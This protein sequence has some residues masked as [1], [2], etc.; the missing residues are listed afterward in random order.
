MN[1]LED[2]NGADTNGKTET[3]DLRNTDEIDFIDRYFSGGLKAGEM[4]I[5]IVGGHLM[6]YPPRTNILLHTLAKRLRDSG[7]DVKLI[8]PF[9]FDVVPEDFYKE[10]NFEPMT[11]ESADAF[12]ESL[13]EKLSKVD[14]DKTKY[15]TIDSMPSTIIDDPIAEEIPFRSRGLH[16]G[17]PAV[18]AVAFVEPKVELLHQSLR[19]DILKHRDDIPVVDGREVIPNDMRF[20]P[21]KFP[22]HRQEN[23]WEIKDRCAMRHEDNYQKVHNAI[24]A[25]KGIKEQPAYTK[26]NKGKRWQK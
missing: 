25:S 10:H 1:Y 26:L 13:N 9:E 11:Q 12:I 24:R 3:F 2:K 7:E 19:V 20:N 18:M 17:E 6:D 14:P 16:F 21:M 22:E 15:I 4:S 8:I 5:G 23:T